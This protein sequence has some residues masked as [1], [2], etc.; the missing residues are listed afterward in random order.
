MLFENKSNILRLN[1]FHYKQILFYACIVCSCILTEITVRRAV[2]QEV[3]IPNFWESSERFK[4]PDF[5][6]LPRLRFLTTT[7]FPPFNFIDRE[8]QLV[9]FHIDLARAI[10]AELDLLNRCEIQAVPWIELNNAL[11]N[12]QGEAI[13]AGLAVTEQ[14][15]KIYDFSRPYMH[16]PARFIVRKDSGLNAPAYDALFRKKT[17]VVSGSAHAAYFATIFSNRSSQTYPFRNNALEALRAGEVDAVFSDAVSLSFWLSSAAAEDCCT[18]LDGP[19]LSTEF[20]GN[21]LS[22]A[23]PKDSQDLVDGM[24]F[25][26]ARINEQGKF[27]EIYLRYFPVGLY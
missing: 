8:Q 6:Q 27:A 25:A 12:K 7:D 4:K 10:C 15:R 23:L 3:Q 24:N 1:I 20:F 5:S 17:G 9:G 13:I 16:I 2:A 26:L 14:T 11:E 22:I 21:G 19:Y 18:F